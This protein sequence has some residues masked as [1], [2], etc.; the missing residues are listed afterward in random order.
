MGCISDVNWA[1]ITKKSTKYLG[2]VHQS[3][4]GWISGE[5]IIQNEVDRGDVNDQDVKA[6]IIE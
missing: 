1:G 6:R 2:V 3:A 4:V 5:I